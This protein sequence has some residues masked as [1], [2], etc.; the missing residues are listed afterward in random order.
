[1]LAEE[2]M[3]VNLHNR[4]Q[5]FS[6]PILSTI[7]P[8]QNNCVN[9]YN[10][11]TSHS[12]ICTEKLSTVPNTGSGIYLNK[13]E[14]ISNISKFETT[15]RTPYW[16]NFGPSTGNTYMYNIFHATTVPNLINTSHIYFT[17]GD[18]ITTPRTIYNS[19]FQLFKKLK[20]QNNGN[21]SIINYQMHR[22]H[23]TTPVIWTMASNPIS[24]SQFSNNTA[25]YS[26]SGSETKKKSIHLYTYDNSSTDS[27]KAYMVSDQ[28]MNNNCSNPLLEINKYCTYRDK[29][30]IKELISKISLQTTRD[31][32]VSNPIKTTMDS[33]TTST[34]ISEL[35]YLDNTSSTAIS[36][37]VE[38]SNYSSE[39]PPIL[40]N[41]SYYPP[42]YRR[43]KIVQINKRLLYKESF[44]NKSRN[45]KTTTSPISIRLS[46]PKSREKGKYTSSTLL[47]SSQTTPSTQIKEQELLQVTVS[48]NNVK[49]TKNRFQNRNRFRWTPS[50]EKRIG[51]VNNNA[52][53]SSTIATLLSSS[54]QVVPQRNRKTN[55]FTRSK[56]S[57]H[58]KLTNIAQMNTTRSAID[59]HWQSTTPLASST[60]ESAIMRISNISSANMFLAKK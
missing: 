47:P 16:Q 7:S 1:M 28:S 45:F 25:E 43:G 57:R 58:N 34:P 36:N 3:N 4:E 52:S 32:I 56:L 44:K 20:S 48:N 49:K 33:G 9:T 21:Q 10:L 29:H 37:A 14:Y 13:S 60:P 24:L 8:L 22:L 40:D 12:N 26:N 39:K 42:I 31:T 18:A 2:N 11:N 5:Y 30:S 54:T 59:L 6:R 53:T 35:P 23:T 55:N 17:I 38:I 15:T 27:T 51:K 46:K 19:Q 41:T 50:Y